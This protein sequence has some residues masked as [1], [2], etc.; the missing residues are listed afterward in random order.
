[1]SDS[2]IKER[3]LSRSLRDPETGCLRWTGARNHKGYGQLSVGGRSRPVHRLAYDALIA[4]GWSKGGG[5]VKPTRE[6]LVRA[7]Y[8]SH[9][10]DNWGETASEIGARCDAVADALRAD[11]SLWADEEWEYA[12][13]EIDGSTRGKFDGSRDRESVEAWWTEQ[14]ELQGRGCHLVRRR[15]AG[16]WSPV[17]EGADRER[18]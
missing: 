13:A 3:L 14:R 6:T 7:L 11:K 10:S 4:L 5:P 16:P 9:I 1:M 2:E 17:P 8:L 15:K 18:E 12:V